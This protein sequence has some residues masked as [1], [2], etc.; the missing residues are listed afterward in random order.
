VR[1]NRTVYSTVEFQRW[2]ERFGLYPA[3][4]FVITRYLDRSGRTLEGGTGGGRILL[5]MKQ[6]G[7]TCLRGYDFVPQFI[8]LA[9]QRDPEGLIQFDVQDATGLAYPDASFDQLVYLQQLLCFMESDEQRRAAV[10]EAYRVLRPGGVALFSVLCYE[11]RCN[12][13]LGRWYLRYVRGLRRLRGSKRPEQVQSWMRLGG[14]WNPGCLLD[15]PPYV[16]WFKIGDLSTLLRQAGFAFRAIGSE[17]QIRAG[18]MAER[19]EELLPAEL[20][21][22][23][24]C[25]C[26]R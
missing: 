22:T 10:R 16:Y 20:A 18:Q 15:R 8:E 12:S 9:R 4:E 23:L 11:S 24:Y 21:G 25:V 17:R 26:V 7:F 2:A 13:R 1:D 5:A 3:E 14:K 19:P 6:M